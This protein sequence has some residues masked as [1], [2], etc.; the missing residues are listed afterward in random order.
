MQ[1]RP[2]LAVYIGRFQPLH[3]GHLHAIKQ[4]M[5]VAD[6]VLVLMGDTGGPRT[7][8]N[9]W[10]YEERR[11]MLMRALPS[12]TVPYID[13]AARVQIARIMDFQYSETD[14]LAEVQRV[15]QDFADKLNA[16]TIVMIGHKKDS[17]SYYLNNFPQWKFVDTGYEELEGQYERKIDATK[18]R[19]LIFEDLIHYTVGVLPREV[20]D[21]ITYLSGQYPE[22][23]GDLK[24]EYKFIQ[25]YK[26]SWAGA[27]FPPV[28][29]TTDCVVVQSGHILLVRRKDN[30]GKGLWAL[31][32]G[33]I[34]QVETIEACA[35]RELREETNIGLQ[36]EVLR[37]CVK[38]VQVF[39]RAGGVSSADRGRIITHVHAIKLDDA[40]PLAKVKGGDDAAEA[41]WVPIGELDYRQLFSDHGAIIHEVL[42]KL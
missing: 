30:P 4:G 18:I 6:H 5:Y 10:T 1:D 20:R 2:N 40:K 41:R 9:P 8:K 33:F 37:R 14:W 23:F 34:D 29:V 39:D 26:K 24:E 21:H 11:Q 32:G 13:A 19:E 17:S 15:V 31:P 3:F 28:F 42:N 12:D 7:V 16:K 38:F 35:L 27:P 22:P 25:A 36:D